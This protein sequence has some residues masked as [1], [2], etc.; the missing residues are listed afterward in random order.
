NPQTHFEQVYQR[1]VGT[2]NNAVVAFNDAQNVTQLMRSEQDSLDNYQ[3]AYTN[4]ETAYLDQLI[5][6]YGTPY[7]DDIGAGRTYKQGYSGP[8][9]IHYTYVE[10]PDVNFTGVVPD[11]TTTITNYIDIQNLPVSWSSD[12]L[13]NLG[14]VPS[15]DPTWST[16]TALAIPYVIGP[17]G[18]FD[19]PAEWA[20]QRQ[21]P[22]QIQQAISELIAARNK[23]RKALAFETY[24]KQALDKAMQAARAQLAFEAG[25]LNVQSNSTQAQLSINNIQEGYNVLNKW[26]TA[27]ETIL[28]DDKSI[29]RD[30]VPVTFIFGTSDGGDVGKAAVAPLYTIDNAIKWSMLAA[31]AVEFT[32]MSAQTTVLQNEILTN[33]QYLASLQLDQDT[34][35]SVLG[36]GNQELTI[37][38]DLFT[39]NEAFRE[40]DDKQRAYQALLAQGQRIQQERL[41]FRQHAAALIQGYR[42][43]DAAFRIFLNEKLERYKTLFDLTAQY[44]FMAAQAYDYET[45]L[46]NT[47]A[48]RSFVNRIISARALGVVDSNGQPQYAGSDTGDPGLSSALAEMKADWDVLKGRLGFNNPDGYGTTVSLRSED[49]RILTGSAGDEH[50]RDMLQQSRV[51]DL[52]TD[53]DVM[54]YCSQIDDGSGQPVPGI[55]VTFSTLV[56]PGRNLFGQPLSPGDHNFSPSLFA[57]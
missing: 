15:T 21:S 44:A 29:I 13:T 24:D 12:M 11:P 9:L 42:T 43:R 26:S 31:D 10:N 36:L 1:A 19:K 6:L 4:Q 54:R 5:Q 47:D 46:L 49:F 39:I 55:V 41:T 18:F 23:L 37:Q 53:S 50:W 52:R 16:N 30:D 2:L 14:I 7:P 57:T 45:G 17:N 34:K 48:G 28:E 27:A 56:A 33:M 32:G 8:D 38:G 25:N 51:A 20:S 22:G 40:L 3:A 35:T